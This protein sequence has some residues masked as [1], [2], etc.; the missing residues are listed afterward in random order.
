MRRRRLSNRE[1][2]E[3]ARTRNF[4]W[5]IKTRMSSGGFNG[6]KCSYMGARKTRYRSAVSFEGIIKFYK[7]DRWANAFMSRLKMYRK[8]NK[9]SNK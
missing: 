2:K 9:T 1:I 8:N 5:S 6:S 3:K 7:K 4:Y